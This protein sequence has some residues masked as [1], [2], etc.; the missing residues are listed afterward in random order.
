LTLG[1]LLSFLRN[2][3][4]H[5]TSAQIGGPSDYLWSDA[6]LT[7]MINQAY[8]RFATEALCLRDNVT[9]QFTQFITRSGVDQYVLDPAVLAVISLQMTGDSG[10]LVRAGH[11]EF[12]VTPRPDFN[13]F[14]P[15]AIATIQPGKPRAYST[16][17]GLAETNTGSV[18][19]ITLRLFPAPS[20]AYAGIVGKMRVVRLPSGPLSDPNDIP[21]LP[22]RHHLELLDWAAYLALRIVDHDLGDVARAQEFK[23]SFEDHAHKARLLALRKQF[24]PLQHGFG[25]NG[26]SWGDN[27]GL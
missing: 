15:N 23:A 21:E 20:A 6:D 17:E 3:I 1:D 9:Q 11:S 8:Y 12:N 18:S 24:T 19:A 27:N 13:Y 26:W 2:N 22:E 7:T 5:D 10:D 25:R 16:D 14:D 4:L